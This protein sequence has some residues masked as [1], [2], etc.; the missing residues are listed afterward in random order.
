[1]NEINIIRKDS[2]YFGIHSANPVS[3]Q[4]ITLCQYFFYRKVCFVA[5]SLQRQWI[6]LSWFDSVILRQAQDDI[7][8]K[9]I[10]QSNI[11]LRRY[12]D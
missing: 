4:R 2:L 5:N 9:M 8:Q 7:C 6:F 11:S 12:S 1:L 10:S 3:M